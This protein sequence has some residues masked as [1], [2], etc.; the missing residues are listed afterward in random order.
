MTGHASA[1]QK[2]PT[3]SAQSIKG[4]NL[5]LAPVAYALDGPPCINVEVE[6]G[7]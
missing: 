6:V 1:E 7:F 4:L 3:K 2:G 5:E